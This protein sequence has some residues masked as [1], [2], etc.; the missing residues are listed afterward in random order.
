[1]SHPASQNQIAAADPAASVWLHANAGSGKTK[2]LIDRVARLLL[3]GVEPQH[4]L[5][6]TYTK[7][8][9]A[10]MQNRLFAR[11]G[12]WAMMPD[13]KLVDAM[14]ALGPLEG[15][16][17]P[18]IARAR[19]LFARAIETPG[20]LRI[21]TIHSFCSTLLRRFPL[22]AGVNPQFRELDDRSAILM[23]SE[24]AE[25]LASGDGAAAFRDLARAYNGDDLD[26]LL[27]QAAKV[28]AGSDRFL[29][30]AEARA[31]F[32]VAQDESIKSILA[33]V[34]LG[35]ERTLI[36]KV[37]PAL[38]PENRN[39][40]AWL[41]KF[42]RL[43]ADIADIGSLAVLESMFISAQDAK[44]T[45]NQAKVG[46]FPS[47]ASRAALGDEL[48]AWDAFMCRV[49]VARTRRLGL[50]AATRTAA[51]HGFARYFVPA[52]EARKAAHGMLDFDDLITRARALLTDHGVAQWVLYRL[53]GGIDHILVDEA[54]DTSPEQWQVLERLTDA[55]MDGDSARNRARTIFVV[56]DKKQSIYSFQ[57]AD[58]SA[59][60][61][62][63]GRFR[64]RL[65]Q[66]GKGLQERDM[67]HSFRSSP[68]ILEV[69]D[70]TFDQDDTAS[71]GGKMQHLAFF[72][73]MPG[74]VEVWPLIASEAAETEEDGFSPVD[75]TT[76]EHHAV[77][78]G[79]KVADWI[80]DALASGMQV[81]TRVGAK[82]AEP[83]DFLVL[84]KRR[85]KIFHAVIAACKL[86]G[87]AIAGADRLKLGEELVVNDMLALLSFLANDKDDLALAAVLRSPF[88]GLSEDQLYRLAHGRDG[89][90]WLRLEQQAATYP[91]VVGMLQDLRDGT[92]LLRPYDLLER[93]L[94]RHGGRLRLVARLGQEAEDAI[95]EVL[96][97]ALAYEAAEVP[98]LTGFLSWL[99]AGDVQVKR[100]TET[101][102]GQI[103]VM[104][105]H[106][107]KGLEAPVVILPD[108]ADYPAKDHDQ[109]I[110]VAAGWQ[111]P[112]SNHEPESPVVWVTSSADS[113]QLMLAE[114]AQRAKRRAA[115]DDRLLYVAMTRAQS[116]LVVGAAGRISKESRC[117][118]RKISEG[119]E[120]VGAQMAADGV[121]VHSFGVWPAPNHRET[122]VKNKVALPAWVGEKVEQP[123]ETKAVLSPSKLG[124]AKAL[125]GEGGQDTAL[126]M[127]RG[128]RLHRLLEHLP[129]H[130]PAQ[131]GPVA[132]ALAA[133]DV[134]EEA[135]LVITRQPAL[136]APGTLAEVA[137]TAEVGGRRMLGSID[138]LILSADRVLAVDFKSNK[139]VP[140]RAEEVPEGILR[141]MGAYAVA[142]GQI[143]PGRRIETAILWTQDATLLHLDPD[144]VS[145]A[146]ASALPID[147][148][149]PTA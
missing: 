122:S 52:Y 83:G 79:N 4:V 2:V 117:W 104:T 62:M 91:V 12:E 78:M 112:M 59:F 56:G 39:Q 128:D 140:R 38:D 105:V 107:A 123:V 124:G 65:A 96:T 101:G 43:P 94:T 37:M 9:A 55:F 108:T 67:L 121:L 49:E 144:I 45:P 29:D 70:A 71:V 63:K 51:L 131:W 99:G 13:A 138:R 23:R 145:A 17:L 149:T 111:H 36:D 46:S 35:N 47:R 77:R 115:E 74:R 97:Q 130:D 82:P 114:K 81:P 50:I 135:R 129:N 134:L 16:R 137:V 11:L 126:A 60:D 54:Q 44:Q 141:Q 68:A 24:I 6:L 109:V 75:L 66:V 15:G 14:A 7:A 89:A 127:A 3:S 119:M 53:D 76:E 80:A 116:L 64:S 142:L 86:R 69:V 42:R 48:E 139:V 57:G 73:Q 146:L 72:D 18:D 120:R 10:E 85:S 58:V 32:G 133:E 92:D 136:F 132:T 118:H 20:G 34:F 27:A 106:G 30:D 33:D 21:Q 148:A 87:L 103:R 40:R 88:G 31:L 102:G 100:Q 1:M 25:E 98:S 95:D 90:L 41:R 22:E 113:P 110:R 125:P 93:A 147:V 5:C 8:A 26:G 143:Y 61:A 28:L 19:Q 84:V